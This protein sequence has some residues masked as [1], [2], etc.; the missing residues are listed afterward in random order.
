MT[1][2]TTRHVAARFGVRW[3]QVAY[4]HLA[5]HVRGGKQRDQQAGQDGLGACPWSRVR[6]GGGA[7]DPEGRSDDGAD[8]SYHRVRR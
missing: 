4:A 3:Y 5:G 8:G 6:A 1:Y 7:V 2:L